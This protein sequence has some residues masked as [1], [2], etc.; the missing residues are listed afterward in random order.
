LELSE[1]LVLLR[2]AQMQV[3]VI[4]RLEALPAF[5]RFDIKTLDDL[6]RPEGYAILPGLQQAWLGSHRGAY[7]HKL[8][9][10]W[11]RSWKPV[12]ALSSGTVNGVS[13]TTDY[14]L[15]TSLGGLG[16]ENTDPERT[17]EASSLASRKL[18]FWL[19][20]HPESCPAAMPAIA[21]KGELAEKAYR[22]YQSIPVSYLPARQALPPGYVSSAAVIG[23]VERVTWMGTF[24]KEE[25]GPV[26]VRS[27]AKEDKAEFLAE[28]L[29]RFAQS[30][31]RL[32]ST[33]ESWKHNENP[34]AESF[35]TLCMRNEWWRG[36]PIN[37]SMLA[38]YEAPQ[39][40]Y[41]LSLPSTPKTDLRPLGAPSSLYPEFELGC[42]GAPT[43]AIQLALESFADGFLQV[44]STF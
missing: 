22:M 24:Q 13:Y 6:F 1:R 31:A 11:I 20:H 26:W 10:E 21:F 5:R 35:G 33:K 27:L 32:W 12:L 18:A 41:R 9:L 16:L 4:A 8:N 44:P 43:P 29:R 23:V 30:R 39:R 37:A 25:N 34:H 14:W 42:K 40:C 15:P 7:R 28:A 38:A 3:E 36:P 19:Y 17:L 2:R